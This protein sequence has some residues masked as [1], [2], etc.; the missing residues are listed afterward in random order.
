MPR[1][2]WCNSVHPGTSIYVTK[3]DEVLVLKRV[4]EHGSGQWAVPGGW[5]DKGEEDLAQAALRELAEEC[6]SDLKVTAPIF[7]GITND[8][9]PGNVHS[10]TLHY[11]CS[12]VQ[13]EPVNL[14]PE[15]ASE[16]KWMTWREL[17]AMPLDQRF[18]PINNLL[19]GKRLL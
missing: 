18:L 4:A 12:W 16:V 11:F 6:G 7:E 14:E 2:N 15:K 5:I 1:L 17:S 3:G 9:F 10:L 13:G 19:L 8:I